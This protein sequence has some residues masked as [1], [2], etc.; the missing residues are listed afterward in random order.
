MADYR[1]QHIVGMKFPPQVNKATGRFETVA[2][3]ESIKESIRIILTT[4][5]KERFIRPEFGCNILEFTFM[6]K[7]QAMLNLM[8]SNV[9]RD[10]KR[11]EP[12]IENVKV[13][14]ADDSDEEKVFINV[15]YT[16]KDSKENE[17]VL[18]EL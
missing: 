17:N 14:L 18:V 10:L 7:N 15:E 13:T 3:N 5:K 12:R 8:M 2:D 6:D 4:G 1:K 9:E 16:V 11:N